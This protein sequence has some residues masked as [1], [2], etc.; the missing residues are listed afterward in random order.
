MALTIPQGTDQVQSL[1]CREW[2]KE[3][4]RAY[5]KCK[6]VEKALQRHIQ[7]AIEDKYL[8]S[9]VDNNT[10]LLQKDIQDILND[11]FDLY[12]KVPL[13]E[14]KQ[15][16][17]KIRAM[18]YHPVDPMILLFSPMKKIKKMDIAAKI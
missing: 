6:N 13:E 17:A 4:K 15:K 7:D 16:E 3:E 14:V 8:E 11:L 10:Q 9:L 18:T 5:Y 1:N 2:H 12:R